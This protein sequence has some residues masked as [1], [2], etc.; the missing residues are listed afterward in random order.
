MAQVDFSNA[1]I[2][3]IGAR[4]ATALQYVSL[5]TQNISDVSGTTIVSGASITRQVNE[6]KQLVYLYQGAFT[7]SG[8]E[9][10]VQQNVG[11]TTHSGFK[12]SNVSFQSGDTY[13]FKIRADLVCQ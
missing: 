1:R 7:T 9:F 10:Y 3:P 12:I 13:S 4:N 11:R 8:T 2:V 5:N 6:Q